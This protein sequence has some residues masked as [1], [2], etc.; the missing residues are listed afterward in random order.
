MNWALLLNSLAVA[1]LATAGAVVAGF[2]AALFA[3]ACGRR[4][5]LALGAC[6][7][8]VLVL[9]PFLVANTWLHYFGLNGAWRGLVPFNVLTLP[10]TAW[11]LILLL[12]PVTF[13]LV[14]G[15][16]RQLHP[17]HFESDPAVRGRYLLQALLIPFARPALNWALVITLV[18][19]LNQFT[20]PALL[21]TKVLPAEMW[22]RYNTELD[23]WGTLRLSLPLIL[24]PLA[25]LVWLRTKPVPWKQTRQ[26]LTPTTVRRQIGRLWLVLAFAITLPIIALS[27]GLPLFQLLSAPRTWAE[28]PMALGAAGTSL[29]HSILYALTAATACTCLSLLVWHRVIRGIAWLLF[30]IPGMLLGLGLIRLFNASWSGFLFETPLLVLIGLTL[31]YIAL[32]ASVLAAQARRID[33]NLIDDAR[34]LGL[35]LS[36]RIRHLYAPALAAPALVVWYCVYLLCLWDVETALLL[37]PPGGETAALRV[38]NLLHA[39][40]SAQVNALCLALLALG[41]LPLLLILSATMLTS[42]KRRMS[43]LRWMPLL[44]ATGMA[45]LISG[46]SKPVSSHSTPLDNRFFAE[47]TVVASRGTGPGEVNKPR[48]ITVGGDNNVYVVDMTGRVQKLSS[49]GKI[50]KSWQMEKTDLGR[51][52]GLGMDREGNIMVNEPHYSKVNHFTTN[53]ALVFRW[54]VHGTNDGQLAFPRAV[55]VNS[56]NEIYLSEY[57]L[58][59]RVQRFSAHGEKWLGTFGTAGS[60]PGQ[61]NR[62][63]GVCIDQQDRVY[64]A[65]SC[66]HRIQ[67]FSDQGIFLYTYG[68]A[69]TGLGELSYPYDI[70]VDAQ[71]FQF[72]CEFGNSRIQVFDPEGKPLEIIGGPGSAPGQFNNPWGVALDSA[73]N[74]YVADALNHRVQKLARRNPL[75]QAQHQMDHAAG[76][77][78]SHNPE[79]H[80]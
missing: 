43:L 59:E 73:G 50:L 66:N 61:F 6:G 48:S 40:Y 42:G 56:R 31:R 24:G 20:V 53:G 51:P 8:L 37:I 18:L 15:G 41:L 26:E 65:D 35:T 76:R 30:L 80:S 55:A 52:K 78:T 1:F 67:V 46:C 14:L 7:V 23:A 69:G 22:V 27:L 63:E 32:P 71:G 62:P 9:P 39:G 60:G 29:V 12:W 36:Q 21:Q 25:L 5:R 64:V 10:G 19:A 58:V 28:L 4:V 17:A 68:K 77:E 70:C 45:G 74:L 16:W 13:L 2:A 54:G 47:A 33:P 72:V 3:L 57:G 38:F 49:T 79:A 11:V 75:S 44:L 34:L